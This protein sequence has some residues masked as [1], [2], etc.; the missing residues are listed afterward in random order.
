KGDDET[1]ASTVSAATEA[2]DVRESD[3]EFVERDSETE[4]SAEDYHDQT[5]M[6]EGSSE[7]WDD[8]LEDD[9]NDHDGD[10]PDDDDDH[11]V[12]DNVDNDHGQG[13]QEWLDHSPVDVTQVLEAT[14]MHE[15]PLASL[16]AVLHS[17]DVHQSDAAI[18]ARDARDGEADARKSPRRGTSE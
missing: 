1:T 18:H 14:S 10:G 9:G 8:D 6:S 2:D 3:E 17:L 4:H 12:S 13:T 16:S 5:T 7:H 11:A 15:S